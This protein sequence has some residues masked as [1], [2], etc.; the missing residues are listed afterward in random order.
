M[1]LPPRC[2]AL[3]LLAPLACAAAEP[4]DLRPPAPAM[5]T[6]PAAFGDGEY[7]GPRHRPRD[8][9]EDTFVRDRGG[10]PTA[11][12]GSARP[13]SGSVSTG[14]GHSSRGGT[15]HWNAADIRVCKERVAADG[16]VSTMHMQLR[17]GHYDGP[18]YGRYG[19]GG[20]FHDGHPGWDDA[21]GPWPAAGPGQRQSWSDGRRP[22]R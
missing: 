6:G 22:W 21:Y 17:V 5:F 3:L 15:A 18:G 2:W 8:G 4:L 1:R 20:Y 10:C 7:T 11:A 19:T 13:V 14:I 16:D 12:D 9:L